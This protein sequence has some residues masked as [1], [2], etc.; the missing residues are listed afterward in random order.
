MRSGLQNGC[1]FRCFSRRRNRE[2]RNDAD[3]GVA[4]KLLDE[5]MTD[6][7]AHNDEGVGIKPSPII[8]EHAEIGK[9]QIFRDG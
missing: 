5:D 8:F 2:V 9:A 1:G 3:T 4:G 7:I 6:A